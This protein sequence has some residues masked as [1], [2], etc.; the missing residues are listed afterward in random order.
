MYFDVS[1]IKFRSVMSPPFSEFLP[2]RDFF[3]NIFFDRDVGDDT[4]RR[5]VGYLQSAYMSL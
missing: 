1:P 5:D 3:F 2:F 4:L